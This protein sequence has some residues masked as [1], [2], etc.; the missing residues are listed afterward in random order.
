[1]TSLRLCF[2]KKNICIYNSPVSF[3]RLFF[4]SSLLPSTF[5]RLL[6]GLFPK[7]FF[8]CLFFFSLHFLW[9][10]SSTFILLFCFESQS[11][12]VKKKKKT[13]NIHIHS[14]FSLFSTS[15]Y[16]NNFLLFYFFFIFSGASTVL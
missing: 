8:S 4:L 13:L 14:F 12:K 15:L 11:I 5:L 10:T 16:N 9:S 2:T 3:L 6:R 7:T 1:M